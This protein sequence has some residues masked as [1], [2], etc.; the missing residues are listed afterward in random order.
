MEKFNLVKF[1]T[2][3]EDINMSYL[4]EKNAEKAINF[5][6]SF[7]QYK[8]TPLVELKELSKE[9]GLKNFYIKDESYR[10]GWFLCNRELYC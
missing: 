1:N 10:F 4:D 5:H 9:I 7:P 3:Q 8:K 2:K 6:K